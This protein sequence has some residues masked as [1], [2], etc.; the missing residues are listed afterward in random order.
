M[1][2]HMQPSMAKPS[3]SFKTTL[4][5]TLGDN[6]YRMVTQTPRLLNSLL[7]PR[8][9]AESAALPQLVA[10][11]ATCFDIG[12]NYGQYSRLL[13]PLV[14][15]HGRVYAFEPSSI[16]CRG[17]RWV[18]RLL[19][20]RNVTISQCALSDQPGQFA[21]T[22]PIKSHGGLGIALAH[23]GQSIDRDGIQEM[24]QVQT[25]DGFMAEHGLTSCDFI[26]ADVEGAEL[27]MLQG[28]RAALQRHRPVLMLEVNAGYL[29][30]H[31][32]NMA[33]LHAFLEAEN[34]RAC[35]WKNGEFEET[36]ELQ[37]EQNHF[38]FPRERQC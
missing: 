24:V 20:W 10:P 35:L 30:R 16:T 1:L 33:Q 28:A 13:S 21:L 25:L 12:A 15:P 23:L 27:L 3:V 36:K 26:K 2:L 18:G 34:Y 8:Y 32:H 37:H 31:G 19:R 9:D 17:L 11:G 5:H 29:P 6:L 14:G 4:R 38:F 7:R 22:I